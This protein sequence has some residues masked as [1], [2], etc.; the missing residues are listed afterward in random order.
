[1]SVESAKA[2]EVFFSYSHKDEDL[3]DEL[4]KHLSILKRQGVIQSWHDRRIGAGR[5]WEGEID[6]HLNTAHIILLLI[7]A[8]FLTSDYCYEVEMKRAME[9]HQ[10]GETRVIPVILRPC[11]WEDALFGKLQALPMDA[12]PITSWPNR[13][14]AFLDVARGIR[15][16]VE[17]LASPL[18]T[19]RS[20]PE[21]PHFPGALL[22]IWNDLLTEPRR[23]V[24]CYVLSRAK[25]VTLPPLS[26]TSTAVV[27]RIESIIGANTDALNEIEAFV[28]LVAT[29][30]PHLL[31][32][33]DD[34]AEEPISGEQVRQLAKKLA[35]DPFAPGDV[36]AVLVEVASE[37]S[38]VANART[39][40]ELGDA[41]YNDSQVRK[42]RMRLRLLGALLHLADCINLDQAVDPA[43]PPDLD[44]APWSERHRWWRQAYVCGVTIGSQRLQ[45]HIRLPKGRKEEYSPI[46]VNP[47]DEEI[48]R[49]ISVYDSVLFSAGINL[50]YLPAN[51]IEGDVSAIPDDEWQRLKQTVETEQ[52]R[53]AKDLLQQDIVQAQRLHELLVKAGISQAKQMIA[54]GRHLEAAEALDNAAALLARKR[55]AAQAR[56]YAVQAAEQYLEGGDRQ[57]AAQQYLQAAEVWLNSA[58]TPE[59]ATKQLEQAHKLAVELDEPVL[60]VR[61]LLTQAWLMFA[62]L[63]DPDAQRLLEQANELLPKIADEAQ[64][65][66]LLRTL[67]LQHATFAM[68]WEDWSTAQRVL[69]AALD[70]CLEAAQSERLDL[71][72]H[73]LLL[74]AECGDWETADHAYEK[75]QQLLDAAAEPWRRGVVAMHYGASLARRGALEEAYDVYSAAIQKL[76]GH[77]DAYTLG[78]AYQNMQHMLLRNG[79]LFFPGLEHHEARRIDLFNISRAENIGYVHE[80][81][82][83]A[84]LGTQKHRGTLQHIRLALAHYWGEGAWM[85]IEHAYQTLAALNAAT[86]GPVEALLAAIRASDR[87]AAEQYSETLRDTGDAKLLDDVVGALTAVRP[88]ACEQQVAVKALGILVDVIPPTFLKQVMDHLLTLLQGSED[89]QQHIAVRRHTAEALRYLVPQ[90]TAEQTNT[91]V[92]VGLDQLQRQQF[93]TVTEELL[94]LL[95]ECF[96][97]TQC[98]VD[99]ALYAPVAEAML[100]F[101]G[102]DHLRSRAENIAVHLAR[103]A[104]PDVRARVVAYLKDHPDQ[105]ERLSWLAFLKEPI[106]E[107]HLGATIEQILRAIN[108][109]PVVRGQTIT[110]GFGA[111]RPRIV[112]NFNE[113][114]PP[115][116]YNHVIDG[117]LEALINEHNSLATRSDAIWALSDL[118]TEV[119]AGRADEVADYLL[120]GAEGTLPRSSFIERE[121]ES[122]TDPFSTFRIDRGNIEQ[123]RQSSLH[124]LGRLY[125]YVDRDHQEHITAHLIVSSRD[126][127]PTVRKGVAM[128]LDSIEGD[129]V[130][131]T[132]LLLA[133]VVLLHD[134]DPG[135]CS[136]ACVGAGHLIARGQAGP[137]AEDLLERL[138]NLAETAPIVEVRV[139]VAVG[140]RILA[141]SDQPDMATRERVLATLSGL[142][143]DVSFRVRRETTVKI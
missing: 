79:A 135:A 75:V 24:A 115:S 139:G 90:L 68:V 107:E 12:K 128:A 42:A 129:V 29:C 51:V 63:R 88:A 32:Q 1:M 62:T 131:P 13:D 40:F 37:V 36:H 127:S 33:Y 81:R 87:K 97:L 56:R 106:P 27:N 138:L 72:Q 57:A 41:Q 120:W 52:L 108:P 119:L 141:Q 111:V 93:W 18:A 70:A 117:L 133:L 38:A 34:Y 86:D 100:T 73:L 94:K 121:L 59:L 132:R 21:Q 101:S 134:S 74:S 20:V 104:P 77:A 124:A 61:V 99:I 39:G 53:K 98:Q 130:L 112:N 25:S 82:A 58:H 28:L 44:K 66:G 50:N 6:K 46:L 3:R 55:E 85:G 137:F 76:D 123:V 30:L 142:S 45:L 5:E 65:A 11:D 10:A 16:A 2:I 49:L 54:E 125:P 35:Q 26:V 78:L 22:S 143:N 9:R 113:V 92:Q 105:L 67:A 136:W 48:G 109:K 102:A 14:E 110:I 122:Q 89:N 43:P 118:P 47:L 8:D 95:N 31:H 17:E 15:A 19:P 64:R 71:L 103:T 84:Y 23:L 7:S 96:I 91:V 126:A 80:L 4:E 116:L 60:L 114:L 69:D 83:I 140:L